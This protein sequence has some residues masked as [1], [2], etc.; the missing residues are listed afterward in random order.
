[1][2]PPLDFAARVLIPRTLLAS[3]ALLSFGFPALSSSARPPGHSPSDPKPAVRL[4]AEPA[5]PDPGRTA[6]PA[7]RPGTDPDALRPGE[8]AILGRN[9]DPALLARVPPG[10]VTESWLRGYV[11]DDAA[12][13]RFKQMLGSPLPAPGAT[14]TFAVSR[15]SGDARVRLLR[16]LFP[17]SGPRGGDW[18]HTT[19]G[20]GRKASPSLERI[21]AWYTGRGGNI[22]LLA[23]RNPIGDQGIRPGQEILIPHA[24][25]LPE[26]AERAPL[27]V[28]QEP[29]HPVLEA[30][31]Q[32]KVGD[33]STQTPPADAARSSEDDFTEAPPAAED[34]EEPSIGA[35][36]PFAPPPVAEG[37]DDLKYG[38]DSEGRYAVYRLK[39]GEALYSAVV[40]RYTGRVDVQDVN[41]LAGQI[42]H[43]S[44]IADVTNIAIGYKV[45]IPLDDLLPEYLPRDDARRQAWERKQAQVAR[46]TNAA[47][48][49]DLEGVAVILDAGHGGRDIGAS[50]NGV[51]E[52]DYVYDILC[53]VKAVLEK[54]TRAKVLPTIRDA[55]EGWTIHESERLVRNRAE[56]LLTDPPFHLNDS[57][58]SVNMR[59]YLSNAWYRKL[60]GEG[61]DPFK[62]VFT[63]IHADARHPSLSGA[64]VYVPGE[65]YRR[66]RYGSA[67]EVY[68]RYREARQEPFVSFTRAERERSEG[69][70]RQLAAMLIDSFNDRDV[71]VQPFEPVRERIIRRGRAWVPAVLRCNAVPVE[72]LIEVSNLSNP[73]DARALKD[74]AYRQRVAE[75]YVEGL[76]RYFAAPSSATNGARA[77]GTRPQVPGK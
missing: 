9:G 8:R 3:L 32:A 74:P 35:P 37:A 39:K 59:W 5:R 57:V 71:G 68:T 49:R 73:G 28:A 45:K 34:E 12:R 25:L 13:D 30:L 40:V 46:Y 77:N 58:S 47:R 2:R 29:A 24:L 33:V 65:E 50:H 55:K 16:A 44:G 36:G 67:G 10:G 23:D 15:L 76:M 1:V 75:A 52:H 17:G 53:R 42:A 38:G 21:A 26:F 66:G 51:W 63:S 6:Q 7:S 69:L 70:S 43:R 64:M 11:P 60:L 61:F 14:V 22:T 72:T 62:V 27:P 19:G 41:D 48:S 4:D 18:V 56:V 54:H 31:P 20:E